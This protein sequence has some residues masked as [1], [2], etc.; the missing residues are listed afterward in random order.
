MTALAA[1]FSRA[2][3]TLAAPAAALLLGSV[4]SAQTP[5]AP[6]NLV[7]LSASATVEVPKDWLTVVFSTTR[8]GPEATAV[9]AQLRTALDT[10]LTEAR[11]VARPGQLEVQ[12]GAF[13][14]FPR[15]Q[16]P[17]PKAVA[18]GQSGAIVGWQGSTEL[19]VEGRDLPA[20]AQL[21]GRISSLSIARVS[22]GLSREARLKVEDDVTAQ[23]ITRFRA[24]AQAVSQ[25]FGF[26]GYALR[27]LQVNS[28]NVLQ[29]TPMLFARAAAAPMAVAEAALPVEVGKA[30]VTVSVSGSVQM[31]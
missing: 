14:L 8:E 13:S 31:K 19:V 22:S 21:T 16:P 20:I 3:R 7:S 25:E 17:S 6:Q 12:T 26:S 30:T 27:E 9:Q 28:D 29:Q 5:P 10:A 2:C 18:A 23:A 4:A 11:K 15:Y 24:R 1:H